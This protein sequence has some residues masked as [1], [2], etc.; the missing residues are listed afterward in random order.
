MIGK[1]VYI[2]HLRAADENPGLM[3]Q[4]RDDHHL[5]LLLHDQVSGREDQV[6]ALR[7]LDLDLSNSEEN[8]N[9]KKT[10]TSRTIT[11]S[12]NSNKFNFYHLC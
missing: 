12:Q 11:V 9:K 7:I 6:S 1:S 2:S 10:Q 8:H 5:L 3:V 4:I